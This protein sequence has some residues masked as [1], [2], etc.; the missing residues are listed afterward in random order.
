M[1]A[2]QIA[3]WVA[4]KPYPML[5]DFA[6]AKGKKA[7][8]VVNGYEK[9]VPAPWAGENLYKPYKHAVCEWKGSTYSCSEG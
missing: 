9:F 6:P 1:P 5:A 7:P 2:P 8:T 4:V 3:N